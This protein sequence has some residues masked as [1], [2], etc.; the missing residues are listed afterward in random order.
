MGSQNCKNVGSSV[1]HWAKMVGA[2]TGEE[3][4]KESLEPSQPLW[5]HVK[6]QSAHRTETCS[7]NWK[8]EDGR[9]KAIL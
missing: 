3:I 8:D 1:P 2:K 9:N 7:E 5:V 6:P 4:V